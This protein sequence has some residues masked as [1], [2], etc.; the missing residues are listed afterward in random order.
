MLALAWC[1]GAV[2]LV[3]AVAGPAAVEKETDRDPYEGELARKAD[4]MHGDRWQRAISEF[5]QWL[6]VQRVYTPAE[7]RRIKSDFNARV[8]GM[9]SYELEYLLDSLDAK[10]R[11]LDTAEARDAKAWLGEYLSAMS[12]ARRAEALRGVPNILDMNAA[13][14]WDEIVRID[15]TR[16]AVRQ[17]QQGV[18]QR[19]QVQVDRAGDS[20]RA[21][22]S[23]SQA[24]AAVRRSAPAHSP[25]RAGGG[26]P[27]FSDVPPRRLSI[28][29][30]P[31]GAFVGM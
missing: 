1:L 21:T 15:R 22:A 29:V 3:S 4:I 14:L 19:R 9:S 18:E 16:A 10:L 31:M 24:A 2:E 28:S 6:A 30:G 26:S 23:A 7:V 17:R 8:T 12:D 13:Q 20:R 27:P 5:R 25:Y 11:L